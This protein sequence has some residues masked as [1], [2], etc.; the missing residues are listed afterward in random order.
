MY[1]GNNPANG[2]DP[3]GLALYVEGAS[4]AHGQRYFDWLASQARQTSG[5]WALHP[6]N[7]DGEGRMHFSP[8]TVATINQII[9]QRGHLLDP[10]ELQTLQAAAGDNLF[11][12]FQYNAQGVLEGAKMY[13]KVGN[14]K[15]FDLD[16]DT[17]NVHKPVYSYA[18]E[19]IRAHH[20]GDRVA[21]AYNFAMVGPEAFLYGLAT[22]RLGGAACT[23]VTG[24]TS[25]G[26]LSAGT[27]V[28]VERADRRYPALAGRTQ[29]HHTWPFEF[30]PPPPMYWQH[31][32]RTVQLPAA[33]HQ[34]I[35]NEIRTGLRALGPNP[36]QAQLW[37]LLQR[38]YTRFP[39]NE[40]PSSGAG[41]W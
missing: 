20:T 37:T 13:H 26:T 18:R 36:T 34:V 15:V 10:V 14:I 3:L 24:L 33:Y 19:S 21:H 12:T 16:K 9:Q 8:A 29:W 28:L 5:A 7:I 2:T 23:S 39:V 35:T 1:V 25:L 11:R 27:R 17:S 41:A 31:W 38:V 4:A 32:P 6:I 22:I 30:G 40:F